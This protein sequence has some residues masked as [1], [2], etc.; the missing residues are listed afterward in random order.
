MATPL[1][2]NGSFEDGPALNSS[3][4]NRGGL[5]TGWSAVAGLE[6]PDILGNAYNQTGAGFAQLLQA[7]D[8][9]RYLDMNGASPTGGIQQDVTGLAAGSAL[10]LS[11]WSS[12]WA[13]NSSG[14]LNAYIFD[15]LT[16]TLLG[17]KTIVYDYNPGAQTSSWHQDFLDVFVPLSGQV[18]VRFT[19][20]SG[21][22]SRGAP[23]LDNV[24]LTATVASVP[25]PATLA[26]LGMGLAGIAFA[27]RRK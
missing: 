18:R 14:T 11:F 9:T 26:L 22:T 7:E 19:G 13:Q 21:S 17:S 27:R 20:D 24:V 23:G 15:A 12:S 16:S 3:G 10:Q 2:V 5:P 4:F 6:M 1:L 25:E 8:G